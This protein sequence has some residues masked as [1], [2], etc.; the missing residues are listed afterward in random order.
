[1]SEGI[2]D[3]RILARGDRKAMGLY[4]VSSLWSL[5]GLRM[6]MII[7]VLHE[8]DIVLEFVILLYKLV[9]IE[10][11]C[12]GRCFMWIGDML[13]R[14]SALDEFEFLMAVS[15]WLVVIGVVLGYGIF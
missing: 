11:E 6:G 4:E 13:S 7:P 1:M 2:V 15:T 5:F 12:Y 9:M 10:M 14:P 3:S 8:G